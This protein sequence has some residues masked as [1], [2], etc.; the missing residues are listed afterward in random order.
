MK[1]IQKLLCKINERLT[2]RYLKN[3][4][5]GFLKYIEMSSV[6]V[7]ENQT[8]LRKEKILLK[9]LSSKKFKKY[10]YDVVNLHNPSNKIH[11]NWLDVLFDKIFLK[12]SKIYVY[13]FKRKLYDDI[14]KFENIVQGVRDM[15]VI[16][17]KYI[18]TTTP[19]QRL[20]R[21]K[22]LNIINDESHQQ[23][24]NELNRKIDIE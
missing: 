15:D 5:P 20:D 13:F 4:H 1:Q 24:M 18:L 8:R 6:F 22:V 12:I 19:N 21:A 7:D 3:Y 17:D 9:T 11:K 23:I 10:F 16:M 2:R 14:K